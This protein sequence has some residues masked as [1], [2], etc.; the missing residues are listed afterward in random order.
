MRKKLKQKTFLLTRSKEDN[1]VLKVLIEKKGAQAISWPVFSYVE[2]RTTPK[3][4]QELR[5]ISQY[6][7]LI[8]TSK[9]SVSYFFKKYERAHRSTL[10]LKTVKIAAIGKVTAKAIKERGLKVDF[11]PQQSSSQGLIKASVFKRKKGLK[12]FIPRASDARKEFVE[13]YKTQ[14]CIV[15]PVFYYKRYFKYMPSRINKL[16]QIKI[17]WVLFFSP[18]AVKGFISYF[19]KKATLS[20][21]KGVKIAVIGKTTESFLKIYGLKADLVEKKATGEGLIKQCLSRRK[22]KI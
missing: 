1:K 12:I 4:R 20:F 21:F 16:K 8:F 10:S 15:S 18:S 2:N 14:H 19:S 9:R 22:S 6:D 5:K 13:A 17:D 7:W 3:L 11:L